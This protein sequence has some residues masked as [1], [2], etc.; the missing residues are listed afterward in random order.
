MKNL[1][2][3]P[4][5]KIEHGIHIVLTLLTGGSWLLV[6]VSRIFLF[7]KNESPEIASNKSAI[8]DKVEK[9][10]AS[11]PA[12]KG[13]GDY[14][15]RVFESEEEALEDDWY[16]YAEP[17]TFEIVG[18]SYKRDNLLKI[19]EKNNAFSLGEI[20]V[21]A[22]L[23]IEPNNK[24]DSTAVAV[25]IENKAVGYVPSDYSLD[26]TSYLDDRNLSGI[27]VRAKIGWD[28]SNPDPAIGVKLDFNF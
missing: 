5:S 27:K 1:L 7:K 21:E 24:F 23:K 12:S 11:K 18:E 19:I 28:K 13:L 4:I 9:M 2:A 26:V 20:E 10:N 25:F 3:H 17:Y 8:M 22:V 6:Y 15:K 14:E 16:D